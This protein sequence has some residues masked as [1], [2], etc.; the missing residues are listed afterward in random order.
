MRFREE[1]RG[2][3]LKQLVRDD[4]WFVVDRGAGAAAAF[5]VVSVVREEAALR[6]VAIAGCAVVK[7]LAWPGIEV[8]GISSRE[9]RGKRR[10]GEITEVGEEW[11]RLADHCR[12][13]RQSF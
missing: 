2:S 1:M 13:F 6:G 10:G 5:G 8:S 12:L 3:C 9:E 4:A 7:G 11:T